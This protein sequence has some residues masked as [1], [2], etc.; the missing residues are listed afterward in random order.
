MESFVKADVAGKKVLVRVDYNVPLDET[1]MIS[2][3]K[4]ITESLATINNLLERGA[5]VIL[6]SHL[7]RPK[8]QVNAKY[9][10]KPVYNYLKT[11]VGA[12]V[13]FADDCVGE[14]AKQLAENLKDGEILLLENVRF[15]AEE[16]KNDKEFA[17]KLAALADIYVNDAFGTAHRRHAS[18]YG[19]REFLPSYIGFLIEKELKMLDMTNVE[20]PFVAVL[21]GAKVSDKIELIKSLFDKVDAILIGGAMAFTFIKA[22][23][24]TVANSLVEDEKL[25]LAKE[26]VVKAKENNVQ[27]LIPEDVIVATEMNEKAKAKKADA[28][29]IPTGYMGLDIGPKTRRFYA[30]VIKEAKTVFWNGPMGVFEMKKFSKGTATIAKAMAKSKG[31][32]IVGGGDSASAVELLKLESKFTHVST[33]GGASLELIEKGSLSCLQD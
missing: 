26:L 5:K 14:E 2:S 24:G 13:Y 9:S 6:C 30:R 21:G 20:R 15:Y 12:N 32:T 3:A 4:R 27:L 10:L 25:E 31:K 11:A 19:V 33:G 16:E 1:G 18:T 17:G 7:G 29:L 28:Y 23:G 22:A 8:G